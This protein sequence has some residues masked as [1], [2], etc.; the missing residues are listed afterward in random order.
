MTRRIDY[1]L[2]DP[3]GNITI[4]AET[5]ADPADQ[6]AIAARLM[7][8]EPTAEQVGF[9]SAG[10][11]GGTALRMAGGEFCGNASMCAAV[12]QAMGLGEDRARIE[13]RVSG[14][15][16]PVAVDVERLS[17]GAYRGRVSMPRPRAVEDVSFSGGGK[18]PAVFFDGIVHVILEETPD[19]AAA[20]A[21]APLWCR[22]LGADALGLM[23]LDRDRGTLTPLVYVPA[24]GTL[25][26]ENSC[27][28][29]STAAA[30]WLA[31]REGTPLALSL[32]Q[33]GGVLTAE[34]SPRGDIALTGTVKPVKK[35]SLALD[36]D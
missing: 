9:L 5:P 19:R 33:P 28:S 22:Q 16:G 15:E 30:A 7:A 34:A 4:L 31:R 17:G 13:L 23:Y 24:A 14:A 26:W 10:P 6:P 12:W 32:R 8:A 3:T 25:C 2:M 1:V 11:G 20:E 18:H 29:G 21:A 36:T 27:A 35:G